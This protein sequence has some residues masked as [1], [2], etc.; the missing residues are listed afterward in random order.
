MLQLYKESYIKLKFILK[1]GK[2]ERKGGKQE[3]RRQEKKIARK[4]G[5][6]KRK[7]T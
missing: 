2:E 7:E 1:V 4:A 3:S 5:D 6:R